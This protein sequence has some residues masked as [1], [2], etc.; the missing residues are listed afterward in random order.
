MTTP[1]AVA[2]V[3]V[4]HSRTLAQGLADL[5]AQIAGPDIPIYALGGTSDGRLGTDGAAVEAALSGIGPGGAVVL[6]DLGSAVLSVRAALEELDDDTRARVMLVD[7]PL[8]EGAVAAAVTASTGASLAEVAQAAR[9][10]HAA[11][12]L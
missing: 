7:A 3:L 11:T 8:V 4:S 1:D 10:A 12:K 2:I 5:L 9:D 6:V